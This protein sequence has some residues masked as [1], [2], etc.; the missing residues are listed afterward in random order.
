MNN[1]SI[2]LTTIILLSIIGILS[3]V[4]SILNFLNLFTHEC[5]MF[6]DFPYE[7]HEE[8]AH[9]GAILFFERLDYVYKNLAI[10]VGG[11]GIAVGLFWL[12]KRLEKI[13]DNKSNR[14]QKEGVQQKK[15]YGEKEPDIWD[16]YNNKLN[17]M[18]YYLREYCN[19]ISVRNDLRREWKTKGD[20]KSWEQWL[21]DFGKRWLEGI[22]FDTIK[23]RWPEIATSMKGEG[24]GG[25]LDAFLR[26]SCEPIEFVDGILTLGFYA[27][28]HM[29]YMQD[30]NHKKLLADKISE[31]LMV[32]VK[33]QYILINR[34]TNES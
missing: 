13:E 10:P 7:L 32:P 15:N 2:R 8:Y 29:A 17:S 9:P 19:N 27:K 4:Y 30:F 28:F 1:Y 18:P 34:R 31:I 5:L 6:R 12:A 21:D 22:L 14:Q 20:N 3:F 11:I 24:K 25:N 23:L 33:L 16:Q 26:N